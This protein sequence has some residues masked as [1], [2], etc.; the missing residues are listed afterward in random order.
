MTDLETFTSEWSGSLPMERI[1]G[2]MYEFACHE[3]NYGM[4]NMLAGSRA[5][6]RAGR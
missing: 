3:G 2:P 5:D 4:E 6:E 1:D